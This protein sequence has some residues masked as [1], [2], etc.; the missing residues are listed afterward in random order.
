VSKRGARRRE[1]TEHHREATPSSA[2]SE[3][4]P[5]GPAPSPAGV[6]EDD[7]K[8]LS[9]YRH[10][11]QLH[12]VEQKPAAALA[13]WDAYLAAEPH[14]PLA[15]D[16]RYDRGLCLVRLGRKTEARAALEPFAAGKYGSYRQSEARALLDA[17]K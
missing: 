6:A 3:A 16:A 1:A 11:R 10:A 17:M 14:G 9:L 7:Q 8:S 2:P 4:I 12:F 13:A 15:V 5:E